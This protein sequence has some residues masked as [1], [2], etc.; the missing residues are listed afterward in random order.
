MGAATQPSLAQPTIDLIFNHTGGCVVGVTSNS[1]HWACSQPWFC[2]CCGLTWS[3]LHPIWLL[4]IL[5][6]LQL[7]SAWPAPPDLTHIY[8]DG[9]C[10]LDQHGPAL[11]VMLTSKNYSPAVEC[12]QFPLPGQLPVLDPT[13]A[14]RY[15]NPA[16]HDLHSVVEL[17]NRCC[18]LV[19]HPFWLSC[20]LVY[21]PYT[22]LIMILFF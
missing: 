3:I 16:W 22:F 7:G 10:Y 14:R 11:P 12:P 21:K 8:A 13:H 17:F 15:Y 4:C 9:C 18:G 2:L 5:W 20:M 6:V 19:L 1:P